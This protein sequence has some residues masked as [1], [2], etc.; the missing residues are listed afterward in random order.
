MQAKDVAKV[1]E[2]ITQKE[3]RELWKRIFEKSMPRDNSKSDSINEMTVEVGRKRIAH[4]LLDIRK[5]DKP[6]SISETVTE[7]APSA[8]FTKKE[9]TIDDNI[10][11]YMDDVDAVGVVY[12]DEEDVDYED[13][14]DYDDYGSDIKP[15]DEVFGDNV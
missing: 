11:V 9:S 10:D 13:V 1:C 5:E 4:L 7:A 15:L 14:A 8:K 12:E 6:E 3:L 2:F